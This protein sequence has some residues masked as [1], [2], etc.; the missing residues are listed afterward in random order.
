MLRL[1]AARPCDGAAGPA[2]FSDPHDLGARIR[3]SYVAAPQYQGN[4]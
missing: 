3:P 1:L 2:H 4:V